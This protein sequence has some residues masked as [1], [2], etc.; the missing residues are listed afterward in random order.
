LSRAHQ[1][2]DLAVVFAW[3]GPVAHQPL[4]L[5]LQGRCIQGLLYVVAPQEAAQ[6]IRALTQL[7]FED[8]EFLWDGPQPWEL[9]QLVQLIKD[10]LYV[11]GVI[12]ILAD[13]TR[14]T[15]HVDTP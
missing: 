7:T 5:G 10:F 15:R 9:L 14:V 6:A 1:H 2:L 3:F 13:Q 11:A 8:L 12:R 4:W